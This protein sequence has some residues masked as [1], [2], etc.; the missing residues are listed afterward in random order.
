MNLDQ[1]GVPDKVNE[2]DYIELEGDGWLMG[3]WVDEKKQLFH[4]DVRVDDGCIF[5]NAVGVDWLPVLELAQIGVTEA[6]EHI[7]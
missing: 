4:P 3:F 1:G 7:D 2:P 6:W 5:V